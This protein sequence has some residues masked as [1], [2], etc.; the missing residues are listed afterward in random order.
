MIRHC[1]MLRLAPA[2][3]MN[4][5]E[6]LCA[7]LGSLVGQLDGCS[8]FVAGPNRDFEGKSAD[9]AF[10][11]TLDAQDRHALAEYAAHPEHKALG[12]QLV[13]MCIGGGDGITVYDIEVAR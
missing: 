5:L 7:E 11:F 9:Y 3:D 10:G 4:T 6:G 1:V 12:A 8:G 13:E 2:A